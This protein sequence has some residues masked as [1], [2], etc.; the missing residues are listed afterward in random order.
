LI[1]VFGQTVNADGSKIFDAFHMGMR[2]FLTGDNRQIF[3][4][5]LGMN[6]LLLQRGSDPVDFVIGVREMRH[7]HG[8]GG[9][10][11]R[12]PLWTKSRCRVITASGFRD[13][14]VV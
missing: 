1:R 11:L 4:G 6:D 3:N 13:A 10:D 2:R 12:N 9:L 14:Q 7:I 5:F 8:I